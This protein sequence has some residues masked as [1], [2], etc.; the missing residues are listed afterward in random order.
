MAQNAVNF[1][2]SSLAWLALGLF[3]SQ[4]SL[5]GRGIDPDILSASSSSSSSDSGHLQPILIS[6]HHQQR[7]DTSSHTISVPFMSRNKFTPVSSKIK[8]LPSLTYKQQQ[9]KQTFGDLSPAEKQ[10][11]IMKHLTNRNFVASVP[12]PSKKLKV[13]DEDINRRIDVTAGKKLVKKV[14][15]KVVHE[16]NDQD[17]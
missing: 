3:S 8:E 7:G 5:S 11:F 4:T 6:G 10:K 16:K 13:N 12:F 15:K 1:V 9:Q 17:L 2:A 14:V